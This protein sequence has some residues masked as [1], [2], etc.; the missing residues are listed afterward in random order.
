MKDLLDY[1][2]READA[3]RERH[4]A[5]I[6]AMAGETHRAMTG[7]YAFTAMGA[8][9]LKSALVEFGWSHVEQEEQR[10]GAIFEALSE[11]AQKL[12][13]LHLGLS[14][15][16]KHEGALSELLSDPEDASASYLKGEI[17]AQ[18]NRDVNQ[19]VRHYRDASL[20]VMMRADL[21]T[22]TTADA[23]IK[24]ML[25]EINAKR[26]LWFRD[27]AGRK[28]PSQKHVRRTWRS[29]LRD[30]WV[31]AYMTSLAAYGEKDA[32]IWHEDPSH[33]SFGEVMKI[34]EP[35]YDLDDYE[36]T[37]H[38]NARALPVARA[39]METQP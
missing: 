1:F 18:V 34:G 21:G 5:F 28:I 11:R 13:K 19:V 26:R 30:H 8:R 23:K 6:L 38:P 15:A 35:G 39:Y 20:R 12:V 16:Q 27:R 24:V 25:D 4:S 22:E 31:S 17:V 36:Q 29:T 37:F 9:H 10:A 33:S 32:L 14:V 2:E 7:P 3:A